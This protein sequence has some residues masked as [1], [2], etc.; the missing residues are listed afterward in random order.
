MMTPTLR[1]T[2]HA[3]IRRAGTARDGEPHGHLHQLAAGAIF[4]ISIQRRARVTCLTGE[5]W[6]TGPDTGDQI[7]EPGQT[8]SIH[9]TGRLVVEALTAARFTTL[10]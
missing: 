8:L 6:V 7:L 9:G 2:P 3:S 1:E 5:L 10:A 4:G